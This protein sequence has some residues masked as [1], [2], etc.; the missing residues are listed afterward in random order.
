MVKKLLVFTQ[1]MPTTRKGT[2]PYELAMRLGHVEIAQVLRNHAQQLERKQQL[3]DWLASIGM[4]QYAPML[5]A[6]GFDD[7]QFLLASGLSDATL[8]AFKVEKEGHRLKL[9]RL[10]MLKEFLQVQEGVDEDEEEEEEEE[11]EEEVSDT[12]GEEGSEVPL[13]DESDSSDAD[14]D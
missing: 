9:Q 11:G 1:Q 4:M 14:D 3:G 6:A 12:S 7:A 2:T 10:Y 13:E 5:H 8:E